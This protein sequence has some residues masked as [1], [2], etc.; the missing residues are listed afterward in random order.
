LTGGTLDPAARG[1]AVRSRAAP[2]AGP[3]PRPLGAHRDDD[4]VAFGAAAD[5]RVTAG[6]LRRVARELAQALPAPTPD[7]DEVVVLCRD[8]ALFAAA[9]LGAWE[10]GHVVALPPNPQPET[11]RA[12]R[13]R[14]GVATVVHGGEDPRGVDAAGIL[15]R[16]VAGGSL[17]AP[18]PPLPAFPPDRR[19]LVLHT[20]GT[21]G[22]G[23]SHPKTAAQIL[24]EVR[25]LAALLPELAQG[26]VVAVPPPHHIYGLLFGLLLPLSG[27]GAFHRF[28]LRA[29]DDP[30]PFLAPSPDPTATRRR[31]LVTIPAHL[32]VL[33][34]RDDLSLPAVA[35]IVSSAAPLPQPV[36]AA[37][38][39][40]AGW[41]ITEVL[42]STETG[43]IA[44][45]ERDR[46]DPP[47]PWT[48]LPGVRVTADP[49]TG[50]MQVDSPFLA[51][52]APRPYPTGD[53][54]R[55]CGTDEGDVAEAF[56]HLGRDDGVLKIAGA[57]VAV[58]DL[59]ARLLELPGVA[60]AAVL[61]VEVGGARGWETWA[62]IVPRPGAEPPTPPEIR[63][64]LRAWFSP[65][66]LPRRYRTV[67]SL[68][69]Q[70]NGKLP[71]ADLAAVFDRPDRDPRDAP[72]RIT[73]LVPTYDNP[74]TIRRVVEQLRGHL[75]HVVVVDDGSGP[76]GRSACEALARDGLADVIHRPQ[77][78]GKG[79]AV[80]TGLARAHALG[81]THALQVDA[82]GQH[83]LDDV[84]RFV[85]AARRSPNALVLG[86]PRFDETAPAARRSGRRVTAFW[87]GLEVGGRDVIEDALCGFRV[88]PVAEA[89]AARP[90]GNRMEFDP[91]I[92]VR[93]VWRGLPVR[94]LPTRVRYV[95]PDEGGVSHFRMVRDNVA[96]SALHARLCVER[97]VTRF[98]RALT[99][100][101]WP[102]PPRP[103]AA[104]LPAA[105]STAPEPARAATWRDLPE[106]GSVLG[107][108]L[109]V[110]I[111]T[112]FGRA[113][114]RLLVRPVALYYALAA[115]G[116]R[117][118]AN[119]FLRRV[120]EP[121]GFW[122]AHRQILRFAQ[123]SLD[124]LFFVQGRLAPFE[125]TRDGHEHLAALRDSGTGAV[126]LG[127]HLGSF[128][129]LRGQSRNESLRLHPLVFT[130]HAERYNAV[131]R[132]LDPASTTEL[133]HIDDEDM[134]FVLR[135]R[136]LVED[137]GIVAILADRV[138]PGGRSVEVDFLGGRARLPAGPYL[139]AASL[140]CPVYFT[141]GIY[142]D[143][144]R[145][146]L[147]CEPFAD[148]IDLPRGRRDEALR[149]HAQRYADTLARYSRSAP[150]NW[151]N[152]YD[153]WIDGEASDERR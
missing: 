112:L 18:P 140:R 127:A 144:N 122:P 143:P 110:R 7:A 12:L 145:Y 1:A 138:A 62:A 124:A 30:G 59:E 64:A 118:A 39:D 27:G 25:T 131:L 90:R 130:A 87:V 17:G 148:P 38:A 128:Q 53:R 43:G 46:T 19:L 11:V 51:A 95:A 41:R 42:G 36:A 32:R 26:E 78:G 121:T 34:D 123:V 4:P 150:D 92:A 8:R 76:E 10:A 107:I 6:V 120:G 56:V 104:S 153:F 136:R 16:V 141:C 117:R 116:A 5:D 61:P 99:L 49:E 135:L 103:A 149:E 82:D 68:P 73:G 132:R 22:E 84:P 45:R 85:E 139:L 93:M 24:G 57:R 91:E 81:F 15:D 3:L 86:S 74:V 44:V 96:I 89:L 79:A 109:L 146:E 100:G 108:W 20:S 98:F 115:P 60:D 70:P 105:T 152:F 50:R 102:A 151:F 134:G 88:Y 129:A 48:P 113:P 21:T 119:G 31:S 77:N 126:L 83:D 75:D 66:V 54:I 58:A 63:R 142:R 97:T 9:L 13:H 114:A 69:R 106:R 52:H 35:R 80:K 14:P 147:H 29:G 28:G 23:T 2:A 33:A 137:G 47:P 101:R 72:V 65:T 40:R 55:P 133:V 67:P 71:R 125:I 37:L 94:N 111:A